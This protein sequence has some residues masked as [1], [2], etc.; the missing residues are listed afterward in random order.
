MDTGKVE[1]N[2]AGI[3][4]QQPFHHI[5]PHMT[6]RPKA[7]M[8]SSVG[9]AFYRCCAFGQ[10]LGSSHV[11]EFLDTRP[12]LLATGARVHSDGSVGQVTDM[13]KEN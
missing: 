13:K 4:R 9:A 12:E 5:L 10:A 2:D 8:K 1:V 7:R 3:G 11:S 6:A